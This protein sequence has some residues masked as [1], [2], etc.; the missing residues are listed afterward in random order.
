MATRVRRR[1][2]K[3][4][5]PVRKQTR[6]RKRR[7]RVGAAPRTP[8][9][10]VP[11]AIGLI[12][13]P[14]VRLAVHENRQGLWS[15]YYAETFNEAP[16][17]RKVMRVTLRILRDL[18]KA[19]H[20]AAR[21][22]RFSTNGLALRVDITDAPRKLVAEMLVSEFSGWLN[23]AGAAGMF[24]DVLKASGVKHQASELVSAKTAQQID[25][26][27]GTRAGTNLSVRPDRRA[28]GG[29]IFRPL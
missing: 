14:K 25:Q 27:E 21:H 3:A 2:W 12:Y 29:E 26:R 13:P 24:A 17:I 9:A 15:G 20:P 18:M 19:S 28:R 1:R 5:P 16:Y 6:K 23:P 22:V 4:D 11:D 10:V 7:S 8:T